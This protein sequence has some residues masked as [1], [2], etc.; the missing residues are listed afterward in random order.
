MSFTIK[1]SP[2][3]KKKKKKKRQTPFNFLFSLYGLLTS[4]QKSG[5]PYLQQK[6]TSLGDFLRETVVRPAGKNIFP[7]DKRVTWNKD[8]KRRG[9]YSYTVKSKNTY[10]L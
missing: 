9:Q 6:K 1:R 4:P 10:R 7:C 3:F 8:R 5:S 2:F